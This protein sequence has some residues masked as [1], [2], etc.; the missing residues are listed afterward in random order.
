MY[1]VR[2]TIERGMSFVVSHLSVHL[3]CS[4]ENAMTV[5]RK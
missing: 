1:L 5:S 3:N 4:F 2:F